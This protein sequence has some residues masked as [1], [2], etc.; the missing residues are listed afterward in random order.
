MGRTYELSID[1]TTTL[2]EVNP[3]LLR[4][5]ELFTIFVIEHAYRMKDDA[6]RW[7]RCQPVDVVGQKLYTYD[8]HRE[9]R[10]S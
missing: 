7:E 3:C 5:V 10:A 9:A 2:A 4:F 8:V 6:S 1:N